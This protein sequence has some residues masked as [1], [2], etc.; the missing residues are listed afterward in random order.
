MIQ[1]LRCWQCLIALLVLLGLWACEPTESPT[2][3]TPDPDVVDNESAAAP[4]QTLPELV[5]Q[6][7][8][9][10]PGPE[11]VVLAPGSFT[12]GSPPDEPGRYP[13]EALHTVTLSKAFAISRFEITFDEYAHFV[14]DQGGKLP[15]DQDWGRGQRPVINI[16]WRDALSYTDWLSAQTGQRY[17]LP[18]EAEWEYAARGGT[19]TAYWWG[20]SFDASK[21]NCYGCDPSMELSAPLPVGQFPANPFGLHDVLGNVWEWTCSNYSENYDGSEIA[22]S[23]RADDS[24]KTIRGGSYQNRATVTP[25]FGPQEQK[26]QP[27]RCA[28]RDHFHPDDRNDIAGFR[29]VREVQ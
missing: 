10:S 11:L 26:L 3:S 28:V 24:N 25:R 7:A 27:L 23:A 5:D 12:M 4:V 19:Q 20:D 18:T 9:G 13:N 16:S 21:L 17:R 22:C 14:N 2:S 6:L 29:V 1:R 15:D 8:D